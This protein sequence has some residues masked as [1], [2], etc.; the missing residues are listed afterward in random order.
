MLP[1]DPNAG[2][3]L[4][5]WNPPP[6]LTGCSR[7]AVLGVAQPW[8]ATTTGIPALRRRRGEDGVHRTSGA[9]HGRLP[10]GLLDGVNDAGLAI[11]LT[12]GGR[13]E[14]GGGFGIPIV[15]RYVLEVC[16]TVDE[17]VQVLTRVPVH[18][19]YNITALDRTGRFATVYVAPDRPAEVTDRA[20]T[21]NRRAKWE[22]AP[23]VAAIRSVEREQRLDELLD[24]STDVG[25]VVAACLRDPLYATHWQQG[26]GRCTPPSTVR[27]TASCVTT[28]RVAPGSTPLIGST[29]KASRYCSV[30]T[31][32]RS[33]LS[34]GRLR[35]GK[36][37]V[38][39]RR[40]TG[41]PV[42]GSEVPRRTLR[43]IPAIRSFFRTNTSPVYFVGPTA[44]NLL[45]LDRWVRNFFYI[46]YYDCWDGTHHG[47]SLP[48][49]SPMSSSP[50]AR[51]SVTTCF[52]TRRCGGSSS[53][54]AASR[55]W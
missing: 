43:G 42:N 19:S 53:A 26:F 35:L 50:A 6:F 37:A 8:C 24:D 15:V 25:G 49:K 23:Y 2:A 27:P 9:R 22:W 45:G 11:S 40:P 14:V 3:A 17:A 28:G 30:R 38:L 10:L 36:V 5:L 39:L 12:F 44:F 55:S 4:S 51:T 1:G 29:P 21:T 7:A 41:G 46:S 16:R 54:R 52:V 34:N 47:Y 31:A 33:P 20:V 48:R 32:P 18:M 13:R